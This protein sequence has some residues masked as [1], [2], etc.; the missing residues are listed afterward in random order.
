MRNL[1]LY[2]CC[3]ICIVNAVCATHVKAQPGP[4][5][6]VY[7]TVKFDSL[8]VPM[9]SENMTAS[10]R[11]CSDTAWSADSQIAFTCN[12]RSFYHGK[13]SYFKVTT[14]TF[15]FTIIK[16]TDTMRIHVKS[17]ISLPPFSPQIIFVF[18]KGEFEL[19]GR[20]YYK[21]I[22][23]SV[24]DAYTPSSALSTIARRKG[25]AELCDYYSGWLYFK[26]SE[27]RPVKP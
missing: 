24:S 22:D 23:Q 25:Y 16:G 11:S 2:T 9:L 5:E 1:S 21:C 14:H 19:D 17:E 15:I 26:N 10:Y 7:F 12:T 4:N 6:N 13:S 8:I 20:E 27:F 18:T 3:I